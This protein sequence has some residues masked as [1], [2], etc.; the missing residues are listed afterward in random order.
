MKKLSV[1]AYGLSMVILLS[2]CVYAQQ[3]DYSVIHVPVTF[4]DF[5][6]DRTNPE[7]EQPHQSGLRTGAVRSTLD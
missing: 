3:V 7:F 1:S 4:Y 5:H 6:S 2:L